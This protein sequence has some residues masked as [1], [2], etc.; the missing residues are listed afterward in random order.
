MTR[1][2]SPAVH[3]R[4]IAYLLLALVALVWGGHWVVAK[5]GLETMPPFQFGVLRVAGGLATLLVVLGVSG[6]LALPHRDDIPIVLTVGLG[7]VA[8]GVAL[9]NLALQVVDA[10]RSSVLVYTQPLWVALFGVLLFRSR[11]TRTELLGLALGIGGLALLLNP[12]AIDWGVEGEVLGAGA[13]LTSASIWALTTIHVRHHRWR[14]AP[15]ALQPWQLLVGIVPLVLLA[16]SLEGAR[17]IDWQPS[18]VLV[19]AFSGPFA[20]AFA[21][22]ASQSVTRSLGALATTVGFLSV[23]MV[24]LAAGAIFLGEELTLADLVGFG[25]IVAGVA[26]TSLLPSRAVVTAS[27]AGAAS[28]PAERT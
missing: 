18:T 12:T 24:G 23:P 21:F 28:A 25:L 16:L 19:L 17:S 15:L 27:T 6:R 11:P 26:A 1:P 8:A 5:V 13:L 4:P 22:W 20:T 7:Q 14:A 3:A 2:S 9:M 10:G